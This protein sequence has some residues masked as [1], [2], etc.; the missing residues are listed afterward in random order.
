MKRF[1]F[2]IPFLALAFMGKGQT[3]LDPAAMG[4]HSTQKGKF[5]IYW[6]WNR[7]FFTKSDMHFTG[8][9]YDFTLEKVKARDR[10]SDFSA[11]TYLNPKNLTIPQTNFRMGYFFKD[12]Y[13]LTF[14]FDHMKYV[15]VARQQVKID[16]Y[17][18]NSD[19]P[20][21]KVYEHENFQINPSFL[22]YEHT[23]GL[24]YVN[25]E[26]LRRNEL[27][28]WNYKETPIVAMN[29]GE[30]IG[31][32]FLMPR[33]DATL[34]RRERHNKFHVSGYGLSTSLSLNL[35][36]L[37]HIFIQSELKGGFI[38]MPDV[39]TTAS[40]DDKASQYF[41]FLQPNVSVG[42]VFRLHK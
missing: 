35:T 31:A 13:A 41:F 33:T 27:F 4:I 6:G 30:S 32:G 14:G 11:N 7:G 1:L 15:M 28:H 39:K 19:T 36:F 17:I 40:L 25:F 26:L 34:L 12:H 20:Y 24:N 5:F 16:G 21:D 42:G 3:A 8:K 10:Q 29:Y 38:H 2:L 18:E 22:Q 9:D 23:D 37:N